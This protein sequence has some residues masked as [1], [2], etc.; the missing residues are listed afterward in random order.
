MDLHRSNI[1]CRLT[2]CQTTG[3]GEQ[4]AGSNAK[5]PLKHRLKA[6]KHRNR[7]GEDLNS[8]TTQAGLQRLTSS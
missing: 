1:R 2:A 8:L 3:A 4:Q 6:S 7:V 5:P